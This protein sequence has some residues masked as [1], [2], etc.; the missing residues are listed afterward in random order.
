ML[1]EA[2]ASSFLGRFLPK[3]TVRVRLTLLSMS[4]LVPAIL[5]AGLAMVKLSALQDEVN[6]LKAA[7]AAQAASGGDQASALSDINT[8]RLEIIALTLVSL[9]VGLGLSSMVGNGIIAP[10][11][12]FGGVLGGVVKGDLTV[13]APELPPYGILGRALNQ[14]VTRLREQI[15][16]VAQISERAASASTQLTATATQLGSATAEISH[17]AE[18][19]QNASQAS[20]RTLG[21]LAGSLEERAASASH[22][23]ELSE[24]AIGN[25]RTGRSNADLAVTAMA[26]IQDSSQRV[27]KVTTVI[28]DIAKQTNL[29]SLNAAIEAAKAGHQGKGFAVVAE[30][31]RKLAERSANAAKEITALI[32]ES[33]ERVHAGEASVASVE[34]S[35]EAIEGDMGTQARSAKEAAQTM[36]QQAQASKEMVATMDGLLQVADRNASASVELSASILETNRTIEELAK[37]AAQL[38]D[39]THA[40][41]LA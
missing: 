11:K 26:A 15:Q 31:I 24:K 9:G 23:V 6:A 32:L 10:L 34:H 3:G 30:E 25:S 37:L 14:T 28:A 19:Q 2:M 5:V 21:Q 22:S 36:R 8:T 16:L 13:R 18:R 17:G 7:P 35:L 29:L 20:S 4:L 27:G 39:L 33:Q 38:R 12:V 41:K 40:F 1:G